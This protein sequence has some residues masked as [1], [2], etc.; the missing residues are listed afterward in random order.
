VVAG[1]WSAHRLSCL[2]RRRFSSFSSRCLRLSS[3]ASALRSFV[4]MPRI[5]DRLRPRQRLGDSHDGEQANAIGRLDLYL[6]TCR[7][8]E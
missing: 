2:R 8:P 7:A 4:L 6:L 3:A 1:P 5:S